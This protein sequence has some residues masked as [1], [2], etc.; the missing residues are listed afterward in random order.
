[1]TSERS[2]AQRSSPQNE[3]QGRKAREAIKRTNVDHHGSVVT[4]IE[5]MGNWYP[6]EDY[7]QDYWAGEG[8]RNPY[9]L[10]VIPPKLQ[11]LRKSFLSRAKLGNRPG[12][13]NT[14]PCRLK[15]RQWTLRRRRCLG[16]VNPASLR[17]RGRP[18]RGPQPLPQ[19]PLAQN[20]LQA[21]LLPRQGGAQA[22]QSGGKQGA[23]PMRHIWWPIGGNHA[24]LVCR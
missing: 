9:C 5:P 17:Y 4:T 12:V 1:M 16:G 10:A 13:I 14:R 19:Q 11:K 21:S 22:A 2:I 8:Q 18:R 23:L 15:G 24:I 6:A 3:E 20:P 7:H